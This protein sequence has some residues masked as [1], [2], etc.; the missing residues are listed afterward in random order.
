M[1][2]ITAPVSSRYS[3]PILDAKPARVLASNYHTRC[4]GFTLSK[5]RWAYSSTNA[6]LPIPPKPAE[7][8]GHYPSASDTAQ[9]LQ[10]RHS[11]DE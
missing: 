9:P 11:S 7:Q 8:V 6:V 1:S 3:A 5:E 10:V 2:S 4:G